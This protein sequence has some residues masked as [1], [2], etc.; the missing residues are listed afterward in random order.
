[1]A[2]PPASDEAFF[3]SLLGED[4][5]GAVVRAQIHIEARLYQV[6]TALTPHPSHLPN[7]RYEQRVRMAVALGLHENILQPLKVLGDIR[8]EFAH[9]LNVTLT[10]GMVD[11]LWKSFSE[12]DRG[13]IREAYA[14]TQ[15]QLDQRGMPPFEKSDAR[16]R[17]ISMAVAID[18]YLIIA[19]KEA[20]DGC[21]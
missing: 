7:L 17:F 9:S 19:E 4:P 8:N 12:S 15:A 6:L 10:D 5:L 21:K 20:I 16:H 11:R 14:S 1:M 2:R 13:T 3:D 18:K